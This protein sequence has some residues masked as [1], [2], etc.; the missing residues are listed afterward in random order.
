MSRLRDILIIDDEAAIVDFMTEAL[1]EE[2]YSVRA[3]Y[4][5]EQGL[6]EIAIARPTV[7]LLDMHMPGITTA[8]FLDRLCPHDPPPVV[9]MTAD[10][11]A[12][13]L[14]SGRTDL[15]YLLKPFDLDALLTCIAGFVPH[16]HPLQ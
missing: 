9:I 5:G 8:E 4:H 11:R 12:T 14:L 10:A 2:G 13:D 3:A 16:P 7:V 15:T 6:S 1:Q